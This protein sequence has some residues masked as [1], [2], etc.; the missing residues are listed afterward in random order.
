MRVNLLSKRYAQA[1]F[2]LSVEYKN[3]DKVAKDLE[4]I[5]SVLEENRQLR[6]ILENPVLDDNK[7]A[8]LLI[9]IFGKHIDKLTSKFLHL[10]SRKGRASYLLSIC[11]A[12]N[13]IFKDYKNIV[14]A[15]LVTAVKAD[16]K[17]RKSI[18]AKLKQITDKEIELNETVDQDIIG[19]FVIKLGDFEYNASIQNQLK[20]L[21]K[22]FSKNLF[23]KQF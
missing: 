10:I 18:I 12:F 13:T 21:E 17:I 3:T 1:V 5:K 11:Y 19:G 16:D 4:L 15:Q 22:E 8:D 20:R 9:K 7:K 14:S 6:K 23:V 2:E